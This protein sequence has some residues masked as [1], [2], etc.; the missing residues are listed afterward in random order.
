M[1]CQRSGTALPCRPFPM[2][3]PAEEC[4]ADAVLLIGDRA[5]RAA[6]PGYPYSYDLGQ[7]WTE[8]TGLPFVYAVWAVRPGVDLGP[9]A[10]ALLRA[11]QLGRERVAE[12]AWRE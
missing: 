9:V 6:L 8:W 11:K 3:Q 4:D 10:D 2:D 7:E 1:A 5:M 12:V